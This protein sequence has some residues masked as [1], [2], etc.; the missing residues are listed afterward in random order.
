MLKLL[1]FSSC[2]Q[3]RLHTLLPTS[4][5]TPSHHST[6][7]FL[8]ALTSLTGFA[9]H[10]RAFFCSDANDCPEPGAEAKPSPAILSKNPRPDGYV[11]ELGLETNDKIALSAN[12]KERLEP[13][14]ENFPPHV[15]QVTE[16]D[17]I[18][19]QLLEASSS[20]F[21]ISL[22]SELIANQH[23][24]KLKT[25]LEDMNPIKFL[26]HLFES[27]VDPELI[28]RY[29]NWSQKELNVSYPLELTCRL[30]HTLARAQKYSR[31]R[32]FLDRFVK[33]NKEHSNF[34]IFH[35]LSLY[36]NYFH[37]MNTIIVDIL[38]WAY[39]V[40]LKTQLAI[41]AF[42][43]AG[44]YGYK[45]SFF[46]C[47]PLLSALVKE[48]KIG[49][50]EYLYKEMI[51]RRIKVNL[52]TFNIVIKGLSKVGKLNKAR[53]LINDMK[54]FGILPNVIT[55]NTVMHGYCKMGK[56]GMMY[57]A[58]A[59][60]KE[61]IANKIS[62]CPITYN[63]LIDGFCKDENVLAALKVF[64]EMKRQGLKPDDIT[65]NTL[66]NGLCTEGK[67]EEACA[68][69]DE[70]VGFSL[71]PNVIT[72]NAFIN[73]FCKKKM[74]KEAVEL[75]DDIIS[76]GL[77][78][79]VITFNTLIDTYCRNG[80]MDKAFF[81]LSTMLEKGIF[82]NVSTYNSL[83]ACFCRQGNMEKAR[84][85]LDDMQKKD[86]KADFITY[87]ILMD[88]L[89]GKRA[90]IVTYNLLIKGYCE[91]GMLEDANRLLNEM[92]EKGLVPNR[93]TYDVVRE[94]MLEK[95]FCPDIAGHL[96]YVSSGS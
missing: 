56:S 90:N 6:A 92:L 55:Y 38:V 50:V 30:L 27:N 11:T 54:A 34:T 84:Q 70:M 14:K 58:D 43:R 80:M 89:Y 31:I 77:S 2:L 40:N 82:P 20:E 62:P 64:E 9:L 25:H 8:P 79:D 44:D 17:P 85:L 4:I 48:N 46:T 5:P 39:S 68:L 42:Q 53:D 96:S 91:K 75:F 16:E 76:Q 60:L 32:A 94:E 13:N 15:L 23:W 86:L 73:G 71:K 18:K 83:I 10:P 45:L 57:K 47:N 12:F 19:P 26:H 22:V 52:Y 63:I 66:I 59:V 72:Y 67:L 29:F 37:H 21:S 51:K 1:Y 36:D 74:V 7:P 69:R 81:L 33:K 61:M 49:Y 65:Y 95:G 28:M 88:G 24:S 78:P 41:E 3:N 35:S 93:I 87:S